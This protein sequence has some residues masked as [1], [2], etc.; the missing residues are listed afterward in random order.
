MVRLKSQ[1]ATVKAL[2]TCSAHFFVIIVTY[3][4]ALF[5]SLIHRIGLNIPPQA[6][7][8]LANLYL[9]LPSMLNPII[10]GINMK[11]IRDKIVKC[12]CRKL[13]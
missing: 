11:E 7:I 2:N 5:S 10:Y 1:G 12:L 6:H 8:L 3:V 4:P 9:L 13:A